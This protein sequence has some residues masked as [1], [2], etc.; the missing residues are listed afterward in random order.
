M[1]PGGEREGSRLAQGREEEKESSAAAAPLPS[2][3]RL[4]SFLPSG[5]V[6]LAR[7]LALVVLVLASLSRRTNALKVRR[8]RRRQQQKQPSAVGRPGE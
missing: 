2:W 5:D 4:P 6:P 3:L 7:L 1:A 8:R